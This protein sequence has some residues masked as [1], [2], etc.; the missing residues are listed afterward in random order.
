MV[1]ICYLSWVGCYVGVGV[2]GM[3]VGVV[4]YVWLCV[5]VLV[6][7]VVLFRIIVVNLIVVGICVLCIIMNFIFGSVGKFLGKLSL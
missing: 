4:C 2:G 5:F 1:V 6:W 3:Y 7:V